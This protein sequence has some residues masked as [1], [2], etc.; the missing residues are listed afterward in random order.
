MSV[1]QDKAV[2][3]LKYRISFRSAFI[4][5]TSVVLTTFAN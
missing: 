5:F 2:L 1:A 4:G 3:T